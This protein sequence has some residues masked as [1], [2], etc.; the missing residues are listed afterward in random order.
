MNAPLLAFFRQH[1]APGRVGLIGQDDLK[2]T[3]IRAAESGLTPD[4]K[5]SKWSHTFLMGERRPDGRSDGSIYIFESDLHVSVQD[6]EVQNGAME[7]RI[8]KW[9][10]DDVSHG[11]VLGMHLSPTEATQLIT[12]GLEYAY[13]DQRLR[14]PVGELFGTLW[15]IVTHRLS[16]KN[17]FDEKY[18][19]QCA[20]FVRMCYQAIGHDP[21]TGPVDLTNT[22]PESFYQSSL[23]TFR[24]EWP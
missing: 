20:T 14:Y 8:V 23:F 5:P 13:D 18:A 10:L 24:Q 4:G 22:S 9:C 19:V 7:S 12:K 1:Y 17:I 15:A 11:C 3:L 16:K 6:W 21:V 2:G